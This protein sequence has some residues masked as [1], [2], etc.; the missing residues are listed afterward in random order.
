MN[1]H[2]SYNVNVPQI[3]IIIQNK[4]QYIYLFV[5]SQTRHVTMTTAKNPTTAMIAEIV[6]IMEGILNKNLR[7]DES[8][9]LI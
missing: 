1:Y 6:F 7:L 9:S 4:N 3:K 8:S 2:R 5:G